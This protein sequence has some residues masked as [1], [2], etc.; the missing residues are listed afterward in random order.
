MTLSGLSRSDFRREAVSGV[1]DGRL[2]AG[3]SDSGQDRS[4]PAGSLRMHVYPSL[5]GQNQIPQCSRTD[6]GSATVTATMT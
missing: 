1:V 6:A 2:D 5:A 4:A 3:G